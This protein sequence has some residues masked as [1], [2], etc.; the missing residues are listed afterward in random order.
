MIDWDQPGLGKSTRPSNSAWSLE[1]LARDL[2]AV[3]SVSDG[4]PAVLVGHS[5]GGMILLTFCRLFPEALG[6]RV[7]G[8]VL[9]HTTYTNP[10]K[11]TTWTR[12]YTAMQKPVM[13]PLCHLTIWLAAL[14]RPLCVLSYLDGSART[15]PCS[16]A[17][18]RVGKAGSS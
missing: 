17:C 10:V 11:T 13:E 1:N 6:R 8:L 9:A 2:E 14:V 3:L 5:F 4:R 15:G 18:S 12:C 7:C 16:E